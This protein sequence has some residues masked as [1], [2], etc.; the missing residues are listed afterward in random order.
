MIRLFL[1][2]NSI[3]IYMQYAAIFENVTFD[4]AS[5]GTSSPQLHVLP[6]TVP[7]KISSRALSVLQAAGEL[8]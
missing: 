7:A 8:R 6:V 5:S 2:P 4:T 3:F 1:L